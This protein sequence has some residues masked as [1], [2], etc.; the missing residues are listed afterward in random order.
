MAEIKDYPKANEKRMLVNNGEMRRDGTI[1]EVLHQI[2]P[3][4]LRVAKETDAS[5]HLN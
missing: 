2:P 3:K 4:Y 5:L 1:T